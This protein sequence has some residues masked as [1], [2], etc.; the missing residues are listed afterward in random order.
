MN[1]QAHHFNSVRAFMITSSAGYERAV[2]PSISPRRRSASL[3]QAASELASPG[4]S[5]SPIS[6]PKE[7]RALVLVQCG[8]CPASMSANAR[9]IDYVLHVAALNSTARPACTHNDEAERRGGLRRVKAKAVYLNHRSLPG[10][11]K[12]RPRDRSSRLLDTAKYGRI[13]PIIPG[14]ANRSRCR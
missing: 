7:L 9:A 2:P 13:Y 5:K 10:F 12:I 6:F 4:A 14:V 11:P 8:R 3:S 1:F